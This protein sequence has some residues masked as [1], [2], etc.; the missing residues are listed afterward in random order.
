MRRMRTCFIERGGDRRC[1]GM[2]DGWTNFIHF[3]GS[4]CAL[5][6][7][8]TRSNDTFHSASRSKSSSLFATT[9]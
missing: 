4:D 2:I 9:K 3:G 6:S 5:V 7:S 8:E 1:I